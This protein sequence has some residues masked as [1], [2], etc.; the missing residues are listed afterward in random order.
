MNMKLKRVISIL[1][2]T[3]IMVG[4][5]TTAFA[6]NNERLKQATTTTAGSVTTKTKV[7]STTT[8]AGIQTSDFEGN[9]MKGGHGGHGGK[10]AIGGKGAK[11]DT[12]ALQ[13]AGLLTSA[14]AKAIDALIATHEA[15]EATHKT[16]QTTGASFTT[17]AAIG[18]GHTSI[19]QEIVN[20]K[21]LTQAEMDKITAYLVAQRAANEAA[22]L[23]TALAPFV[24]DKT[25]TQA[26]A[27]A[28]IA[29]MNTYEAKE[30][31]AR[32]TVTTTTSAV[33]TLPVNPL[34]AMVTDKI[35]TQ[36]QADALVG[37]IGHGG[38]GN[39]DGKGLDNQNTVT[40][41]SSNNGHHSGH[42]R[43]QGGTTTAQ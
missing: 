18:T 34:T 4:L 42:G 39:H 11:L 41:T 33:K 28:I 43:G 29:Y 25:I 12:A 31:A 6:M 14:Q 13:S 35:I 30:A 22:E 23:K 15:N 19:A 10:D 8:Q 9:G 24:T 20:N 17:T 40:G 16:N 3:T 26:E 5:S 32:A 21:I 27:D 36:A 7:T 38:H 37:V 2:A 1:T